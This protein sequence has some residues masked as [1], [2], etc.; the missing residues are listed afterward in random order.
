ML[1][2]SLST[3]R[4]VSKTYVHR[5]FLL[6]T[7]S[8]YKQNCSFKFLFINQITV[9][10]TKPLN[11]LD[12]LNVVWRKQINLKFCYDY[13]CFSSFKVDVVNNFLQIVH[14]LNEIQVWPEIFLRRRQN[15]LMEKIQKNNTKFLLEMGLNSSRFM[16]LGFHFHIIH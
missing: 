11:F 6:A 5:K 7:E 14:G 8:L 10:I 9:R 3:F 4:L 2:K 15:N 1:G 13:I 12:E 16:K